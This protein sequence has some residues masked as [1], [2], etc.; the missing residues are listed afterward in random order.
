MDQNLVEVA[1][2]KVLSKVGTCSRMLF[3]KKLSPQTVL[4]LSSEKLRDT[5]GKQHLPP[6]FPTPP[7]FFPTPPLLLPYP[8]PQQGTT[9]KYNAY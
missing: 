4:I 1:G 3:I 9:N 6:F 7:P 2:G 5:G 8:T